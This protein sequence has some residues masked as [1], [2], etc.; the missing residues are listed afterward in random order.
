MN[1]LR[2]AALMLTAAALNACAVLNPVQEKRMGNISAFAYAYI[3]PSQTVNSDVKGAVF[4]GGNGYAY[5]YSQSVNPG[6]IISGI[7]IKKG[8]IIVSKIADADKTLI[9]SYGE[10]GK[11]IILGGLGGYTLEVSIQMVDAA[12]LEP[13]FMCTAEGQGYTEADDIR[14]AVG[15]CLS[16][17]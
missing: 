10:S 15:R 3:N 12:T 6:D 9:V 4:N 14:E 5:G 8:F 13:V 11:R 2:I 16:G 1:I 17:L 7:L